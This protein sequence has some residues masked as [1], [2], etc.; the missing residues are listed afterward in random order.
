MRGKFYV[1]GL[2]YPE[3]MGGRC[4]YVGKGQGNRIHD[5]EREAK[6][7]MKEYN[8]YKCNVI[9]KIWAKGEQ[10][11]KIKLAHFLIEEDAFAYETALIFFTP[12]LANLTDGGE[13]RSGSVRSEEERQ[14]ISKSLM[15]HGCSDETRELMSRNRKGRVI[16]ASHRRALLESITGKKLSEE[17]RRKISEANKGRSLS[18]E[19]RQKVS[20]SH[21]GKPL[22]EEHRKK[23]S[24]AQ[25]KR[26]PDSEATL[27]KR[28]ESIKKS[29][30]EEKRKQV[31]ESLRG[32]EVS[33]ETRRK[34][35][36]TKRL[37][38]ENKKEQA[39]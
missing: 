15:G 18:E 20:D 5:H 39:S 17:T 25:Q 14:R 6:G 36:E 10:I 4:F 31:S 21:K 38:R 30:T 26:P 13:G 32:H 28:A 24:E 2:Y 3:N 33:E 37:A 19:H 9:R 34:I 27:R 23:L 1:Y 35:R 12:G 22:S 29:W 11:Q 16:S 7:L 8:P